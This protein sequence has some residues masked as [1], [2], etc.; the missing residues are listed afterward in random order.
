MLHLQ[1]RLSA[2]LPR[3]G[4]RQLKNIY[5]LVGVASENVSVL[6]LFLNI[7]SDAMFLLR[8]KT[9]F[10]ST[11]RV[12][13][14]SKTHRLSTQCVLKASKTLVLSTQRLL[15]RSKTLFLSTQPV[16]SRRVTSES[17]LALVFA[18]C[19]GTEF[20]IVVVGG[21]DSKII[22]QQASDIR[23]CFGTGLRNL[24]RH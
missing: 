9:L 11:Q 16:G 3:P 6:I 17:V 22:G 13:K 19:F 4:P 23:E 20:E 18:I 10:L 5:F 2:R 8:S 7:V 24:F 21:I 1:C 14:R 12:L 15:V